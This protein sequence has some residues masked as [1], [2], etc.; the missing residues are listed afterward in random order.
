MHLLW[1]YVHRSTTQDT[2]LSII[3]Q[4][5]KMLSKVLK[6]HTTRNYALVPDYVHRRTLQDAVVSIIIPYDKKLCILYGIMF[7]EAHHRMPSGAL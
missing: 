6:S 2:V 3:I 7:T 5:N 1:D 4:Y